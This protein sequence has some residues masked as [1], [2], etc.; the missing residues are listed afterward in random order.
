MGPNTVMVV[1]VDC[2][3]TIFRI[4]G[5]LVAQVEVWDRGLELNLW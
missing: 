3:G 2:P 4:S 5:C 1:Y